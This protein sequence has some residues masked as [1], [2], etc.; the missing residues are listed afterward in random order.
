MQTVYLHVGYHKT[1]TTFMQQAIFPNLKNVQYI[2]LFQVMEYLKQLRLNK[3][4]DH[5]IK[6]IRHHFQ[7]FSKDKPLLISYEGLS[8]SPFAPKKVKK[9]STILKDLRRVFPDSDFDVHVIVGLREQ[10]D[11]LTSLYIQHI[12]Q[13][14]VMNAEQFIVYSKQNGSLRN[15]HYDIYLKDVETLFGRNHLHV[16]FFEEF[17]TN[18]SKELL[19]LLNFLGEPKIPHYKPMKNVRKANKS[20]GRL[21]VALGRKLNHFFKTPIHP[22]GRLA[23]I[24][25]PNRNYLPTRYMLQN[26]LSYKL[27]YKKYQLPHA[28]QS[29]IKE[30]Y[31]KSNQSLADYYQMALPE[32]YRRP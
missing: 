25:L 4:S 7:S 31:A 26:K 9:Q 30:N 29:D 18:S 3:L 17:K 22:K 14:G 19:K 6:N 32:E 23:L 21:Q 8:G 28:L 16:M 5:Q 1:A 24:K 13:G 2:D 15:Y 10:N 12:H 11:L 27:H 20:Y